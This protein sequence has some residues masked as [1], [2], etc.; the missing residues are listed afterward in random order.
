MKFRL[1][2]PPKH[3][4]AGAEV[5][6][7]GS[8]HFLSVS[9]SMLMKLAVTIHCNVPHQPFHQDLSV[10]WAAIDDCG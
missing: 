6:P 8:H 1:T 5:L 7:V 4:T 2:L 3:L 10:V 9:L